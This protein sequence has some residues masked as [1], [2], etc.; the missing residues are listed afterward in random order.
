MVVGDAVREGEV[1]RTGKISNRKMYLYR[2]GKSFKSFK[3]STYSC[4]CLPASLIDHRLSLEDLN[5][6][7]P[8]P[9]ASDQPHPLWRPTTSVLVSQRKREQGLIGVCT[10]GMSS[11]LD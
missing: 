5:W 10:K 1:I 6:I 7:V 11:Y 8:R 3:M 9:I 4:V 2:N